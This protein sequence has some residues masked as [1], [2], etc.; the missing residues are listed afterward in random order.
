[1]SDKR[2]WTCF[3]ACLRDLDSRSGTLALPIDWWN[4]S[5][6]QRAEYLLAK[7]RESHQP[8]A[9]FDSEVIQLV[10]LEGL[11][12]AEHLPNDLAQT[13]QK[14]IAELKKLVEVKGSDYNA[15]GISILEY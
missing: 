7:V 4:S 11:L 6:V 3:D 10:A 1:A 15:G 2:F 9:G 14:R 8:P 13:V 12:V 5:L